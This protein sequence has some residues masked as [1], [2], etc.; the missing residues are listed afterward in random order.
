MYSTLQIHHKVIKHVQIILHI[1]LS[2]KGAASSP[3]NLSIINKPPVSLTWLAPPN[4][5]TDCVFN[6]TINITNYSSSSSCY[7]TSNTES[8][9]LTDD[10]I[11]RGHNYS[12]ATCIMKFNGLA[13]SQ[14]NGETWSVID[15][16]MHK[17]LR[18]TL[19]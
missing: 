9:I 16:F 7:S 6:Y 2:T 13:C 12:I 17:T 8:L 19:L 3:S 5:P 4:G 18:K 11:T 15:V 14:E 1:I 10:L